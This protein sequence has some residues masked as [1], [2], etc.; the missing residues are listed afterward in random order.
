MAFF[1]ISRAS[2]VSF[3]SRFK[4]LFSSSAS[5]RFPEPLNVAW[6]LLALASCF[7]LYKVLSPIPKFL[8]HSLRLSSGCVKQ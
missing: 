5:V 7:H 6:L 2:C 4:R 3:N 8:A 1:R